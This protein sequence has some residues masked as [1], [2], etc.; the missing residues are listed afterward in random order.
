GNTARRP[1]A[2]CL[3]GNARGLD[4]LLRH[5]DLRD[6]TLVAWAMGVSVSLGYLVGHGSER[7]RGFVWVDHSP[8][9]FTE[10][11]WPYALFRDFTPQHLDNAVHRLQH[12]RPAVTRELL[13]AMFAAPADW[14]YAELLKTPSEVAASMLAAAAFADLRP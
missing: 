13:G 1:A 8:H 12:D 7:V 6:V 5:L 10:P 14:M 11:D 4:G 9:F 3:A 2:H